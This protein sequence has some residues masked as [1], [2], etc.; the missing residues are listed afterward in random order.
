[1]PALLEKK[2]RALLVCSSVRTR[3]SFP[4]PSLLESPQEI[5]YKIYILVVIPWIFFKRLARETDATSGLRGRPR[6]MYHD[7]AARGSAAW[8]ACCRCRHNPITRCACSS[9]ARCSCSTRVRASIVYSAVAGAARPRGA[10]AFCARARLAPK[11]KSQL[12]AKCN[13]SCSRAARCLYFA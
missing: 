10:C 2:M 7:R 6:G 3:G 13:W 8:S 4:S 5:T 9:R 11:L 12:L 1:M